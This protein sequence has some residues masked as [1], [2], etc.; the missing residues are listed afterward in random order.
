MSNSHL[1]VFIRLSL[2]SSLTVGLSRCPFSI[3]YGTLSFRS[4]FTQPHYK[5]IVK[6]P[7]DF[8]DKSDFEAFLGQNNVDVIITI[9]AVHCASLLSGKS[10]FKPLV[11][12][13]RKCSLVQGTIFTRTITCCKLATLRPIHIERKQKFSLMFV[14]YA[15]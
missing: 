5:C 11:S 6:S 3:T 9:H 10:L 12:T 1:Y 2:K 13:T 15:R 4:H 7:K 14:V 8:K